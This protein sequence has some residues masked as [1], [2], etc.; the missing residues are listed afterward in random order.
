MFVC[1][2]REWLLTLQYKQLSLGFSH[3]ILP[4]NTGGREWDGYGLLLTLCEFSNELIKSN[5]TILHV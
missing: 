4:T 2:R 5:F 3:Q 1:H